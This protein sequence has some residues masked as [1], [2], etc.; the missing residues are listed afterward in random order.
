ME[1]KV[2]RAG[3]FPARFDLIESGISPK[4]VIVA[5]FARA[6]DVKTGSFGQEVPSEAEL[7]RR[8]KLRKEAA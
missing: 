4:G 3:G 7:A 5:T 6:G 8:G 2:I 1:E